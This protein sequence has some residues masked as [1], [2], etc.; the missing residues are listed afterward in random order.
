MVSPY[1][2]GINKSKDAIIAGNK[3]ACKKRENRGPTVGGPGIY[4]GGIHSGDFY[5]SA[6]QSSSFL[7]GGLNK[8][9]SMQQTY[10]AAVNGYNCVAL[11]AR[12]L[13]QGLN[14]IEFRIHSH[15]S[16]PTRP[17]DPF[18]A[19]YAELEPHRTQPHVAVAFCHVTSPSS[20]SSIFDVSHIV[21]GDQTLYQMYKLD[22]SQTSPNNSPFCQF[23][24]KLDAPSGPGSLAVIYPNNNGRSSGQSTKYYT[25]PDF[26]QSSKDGIGINRQY[27]VGSIP[28][29]GQASQGGGTNATFQATSGFLFGPSTVGFGLGS[30]V[31][32]TSSQGHGAN[33]RSSFRDHVNASGAPTNIHI[34]FCLNTPGISVEI[35]EN[36]Q[37][38]KDCL[39]VL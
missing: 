34:A 2:S 17:S 8:S 23:M 30:P 14:Y 38:W 28:V 5:G 33:L 10:P 9:A 36:P 26:H 13:K 35:V 15:Q 1:F 4:P 20:S 21:T 6:A 32:T 24:I 18:L 22:L 11:L 25:L 31:V 3:L 39:K 12:P 37:M 27:D 16:E 19:M 7:F 29:P